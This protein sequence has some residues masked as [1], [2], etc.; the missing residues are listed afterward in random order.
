[1]KNGR[2]K[3]S[4]AMT[5]KM[6]TDAFIKEMAT[7]PVRREQTTLPNVIAIS[8][9][10]PIQVGNDVIGGGGLFRGAGGRAA[11]GGGGPGEGEEDRESKAG[12]RALGGYQRGRRGTQHPSERHR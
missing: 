3:A 12:E 11:C 1:M 2:R 4:T 9:G 8:G 6:T 10:V 7:R 5:F